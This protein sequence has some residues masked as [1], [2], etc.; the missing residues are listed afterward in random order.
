MKIYNTRMLTT[1]LNRSEKEVLEL[2]EKRKLAGE[3]QFGDWYVSERQV[4]EYLDHESRE[5][6]SY[7]YV[8]W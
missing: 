4:R 1:V 7:E 8:F 5:D 6:K 2:L 3:K